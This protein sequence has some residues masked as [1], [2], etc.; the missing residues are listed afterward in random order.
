MHR[1]SSIFQSICLCV[2]KATVTIEMTKSSLRQAEILWCYDSSPLPE[3]AEW[4]RHYKFTRKGHIIQTAPLIQPLVLKIETK[5][6]EEGVLGGGTPYTFMD[7]C[8]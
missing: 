4:K 8:S 7:I 3:L 2:E 1:K 6:E 5:D